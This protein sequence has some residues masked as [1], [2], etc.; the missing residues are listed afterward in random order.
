MPLSVG[1][2]NL[3]INLS[4]AASIVISGFLT[5]LS[6]PLRDRFGIVSRLEYYDAKT[7]YKDYHHYT[8]ALDKN[9]AILILF[10]YY[11]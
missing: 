7:R 4:R 1:F 2:F 8:F 9:F 3:E 10:K 11:F 5:L 6:S